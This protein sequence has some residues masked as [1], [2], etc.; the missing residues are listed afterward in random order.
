MSKTEQTLE[1]AWNKKVQELRVR[2]E[3]ARANKD[4]TAEEWEGLALLTEEL[5]SILDSIEAETPIF[6]EGLQERFYIAVEGLA[7]SDEPLKERLRNASLTLTPVGHDPEMRRYPELSDRLS[8]ALARIDHSS[9]DGL[10]DAEAVAVA[11]EIFALMRA[12]IE[13]HDEED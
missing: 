4:A 7:T 5:E 9:L 3:A 12:C 8:R 1:T 10:S 13:V 2:F 11:T 6:D